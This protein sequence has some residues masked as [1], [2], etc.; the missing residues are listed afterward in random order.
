MDTYRPAT[1][2]PDRYAITSNALNEAYSFSPT[3]SLE[4]EEGETMLWPSGVC[5]YSRL[6]VRSDMVSDISSPDIYEFGGI[7][8]GVG[9]CVTH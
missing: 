3:S 4:D 2:P 8:N 6:V 7:R 1:L 9:G 5:A